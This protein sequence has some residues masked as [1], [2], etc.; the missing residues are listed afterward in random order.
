MANDGIQDLLA[1]Q[2][3]CIAFP[4]HRGNFELRSGFINLLPVFHGLD[5]DDPV[6]FIKDFHSKCRTMIPPRVDED[7]V[8]LSA[9]PSRLKDKAQDWLFYLPPG[10]ITNWNDMI[11]A[12]LKEFFPESRASQLTREICSI[13]MKR[14]ESFGDYWGRYKR[15]LAQCPQHGQSNLSIVRFFYMGLTPLEKRMIDNACGGDYRCKTTDEMFELYDSIASQS[16]HYIDDEEE[17]PSRSLY[18]GVGSN[19]ANSKLDKL[20]DLM[21]RFLTSGKAQVK[22][23][24]FCTAN[25]HSTDSCPT[26]FE[27][28]QTNALGGGFQGPPRNQYGNNF[29]NTY[30]HAVKSPYF[31]YGPQNQNFLQYVPKGQPPPQQSQLAQDS[32]SLEDMMR[33][34]IANQDRFSKDLAQLKNET[35]A[36]HASSIKSLEVQLGQLALHVGRTDEKGK[37]P[38]QPHPNPNANVNVVTLR[39]GRELEEV[40]KEPNPKEATPK[41]KEVEQELEVQPS[42]TETVHLDKEA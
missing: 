15:L 17:G 16:R 22:A 1:H 14:G 27:N 32:G 21:E 38:S 39:S 28:E 41:S 4:A 10:S 35:I 3:H 19:S 29:S 30:N 37:L 7:E 31:S 8:K 26:L 11:S 42:H 33:T 18:D 34:L 2:P 9:F 6:T 24:G 5:R 23:C 36:S 20:T 40:L 25:D 13:K 12:F